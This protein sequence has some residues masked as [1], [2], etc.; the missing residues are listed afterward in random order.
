MGD[1]ELIINQM[2]GTYK[3]RAE[4]MIQIHHGCKEL[5]AK[6]ESISFRHV[7]REQNAYTD[8]LAQKAFR[9]NDVIF[10]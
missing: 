1:S 4:N 8:S 10:E 3:V 9:P 7:L 2:N 6:Y 5:A